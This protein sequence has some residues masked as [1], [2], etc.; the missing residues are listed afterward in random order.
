MGNRYENALK[1][2]HATEVIEGERKEEALSDPE[3]DIHTGATPAEEAV[4]QDLS[5]EEWADTVTPPLDSPRKNLQL[6]L[7]SQPMDMSMG[8][9]SN[10]SEEKNTIEKNKTMFL[11][12]LDQEGWQNFGWSSIRM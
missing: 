5:D 9:L 7:W 4:L 12:T 11:N 10:D 3:E 6:Q 1:R 8:F 2:E